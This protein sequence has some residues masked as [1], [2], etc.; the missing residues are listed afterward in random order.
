[1][2]FTIGPLTITLPQLL[3]LAMGLVGT[4][5]IANSLIQNQF[6][7][8]MAMVLASPCL[9]I[10]IAIAFFEVSEMNLLSFITKMIQNHFLDVTEKFQVQYAPIDPITTLIAQ[11]KVQKKT[12]TFT[13]KVKSF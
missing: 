4:F 9:I 5:F 10:A 13:S 11:S 6:G 2:S 7:K 8:G 1:M 3:L 12:S